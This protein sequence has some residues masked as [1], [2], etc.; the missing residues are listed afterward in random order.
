MICSTE[1]RFLSIRLAAADQHD[2]AINWSVSL[3]CH[4]P[5]GSRPISTE[6]NGCTRIVAEEG[7]SRTHQTR[8]ARLNGFEARAVH[9]DPILL[10]NSG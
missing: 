4:R 7:G 3:H 9:R 2:V 10:H 8:L 5:S 6:G 1:K